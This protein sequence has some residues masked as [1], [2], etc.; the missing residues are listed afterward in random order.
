MCNILKRPNIDKNTRKIKR[1]L[2]T[3]NTQNLK[4]SNSGFISPPIF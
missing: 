3:D 2:I 4:I 1:L